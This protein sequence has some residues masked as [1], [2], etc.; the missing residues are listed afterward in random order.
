MLIDF[1]P[2]QAWFS[3]RLICEW[4]AGGHKIEPAVL[5]LHYQR[6][7]Y[8][9]SETSGPWTSLLINMWKDQR[10]SIG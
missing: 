7:N 3:G 8:R 1:V 4:S 9:Q 2:S 10:V 6:E 5:F